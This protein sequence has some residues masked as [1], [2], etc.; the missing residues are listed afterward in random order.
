MARPTKSTVFPT[1]RSS[2]LAV[3]EPQN[4]LT[5]SGGYFS[6]RYSPLK[7][8]DTA[9]VKNLEIKW[10]LPNQ[11]FGAWQ[12]SPIVVEDRKST[13]QN[14]SHPSISYDVFCLKKKNDI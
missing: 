8:V 13:R 10:I 7:Q 6:Q 1:R 14:S 12:S 3:E 9:N 4:W 5:Y 2:D 11:V